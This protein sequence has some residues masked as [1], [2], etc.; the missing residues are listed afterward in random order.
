M[1]CCLHPPMTDFHTRRIGSRGD[2]HLRMRWH[3]FG[4]APIE[5]FES[6]PSANVHSDVKQVVE[7]HPHECEV[8]VCDPCALLGQAPT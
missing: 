2:G 8:E 3:S 7:G 5:P 4:V 6:L 1:A